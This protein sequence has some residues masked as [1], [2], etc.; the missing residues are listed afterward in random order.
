MSLG[1]R[2]WGFPGAGN[3]DAEPLGTPEGAAATS[4]QDSVHRAFPV[5]SFFFSGGR[6][7]GYFLFIHLT[8]FTGACSFFIVGKYTRE[9]DHPTHHQAHSSAASAQSPCPA[10]SPPSPPPGLSTFPA[11]TLSPLNRDVPSR[12]AAL[13]LLFVVS[14]GPCVSGITGRPFLLTPGGSLCLFLSLLVLPSLPRTRWTDSCPPPPTPALA[15]HPQPSGRPV[16][17][18]DPEPPEAGVCPGGAVWLPGVPAAAEGRG[19]RL[20]REGGPALPVGR[21]QPLP[22]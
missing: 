13:H 20:L 15:P 6:A 1:V 5:L 4:P 22:G 18:P 10:P 3:L 7:G 8:A 11:E 12:P 17:L 2:V 14:Q 21:L 9:I 19:G 16:P